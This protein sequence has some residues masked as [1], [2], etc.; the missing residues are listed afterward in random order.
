MDTN[1]DIDFPTAV[2]YSLNEVYG[3][4]AITVLHDDYP[5]VLVVARLGSPFAI[6]LGNTEYFIA[7]DASP[8]SLIHI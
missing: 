8:L 6:G 5:G 2:R 7:S 3:A 4:Y 1:P